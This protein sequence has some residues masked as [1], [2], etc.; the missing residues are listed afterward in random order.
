MASPGGIRS[1]NPACVIGT[2][3]LAFKK[4]PLDFGISDGFTSGRPRH[5]DMPTGSGVGKNSVIL[6]RH[7]CWLRRPQPETLCFSYQTSKVPVI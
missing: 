4:V 3:R 7:R 1:P 5:Q 2:R 6:D